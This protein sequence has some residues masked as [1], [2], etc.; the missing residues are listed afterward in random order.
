MLS[1]TDKN[2]SLTVALSYIGFL[3]AKEKQ[4]LEYKLISDNLD[5]PDKLELISKEYISF[6][7]MRN[8]GRSI[9]PID[10]L[11][12][13]TK[14]A[15]KIMEKYGIG[16]LRNDDNEFPQL[17]KEIH[18]MPYALYYRGN[19]GCLHKDCCAVV[20]TRRATTYGRKAAFVL[21]KEL[22]EN[23]ITVVSGLALG[24]DAMAHKGAVQEKKGATVAVLA[25]GLDNIYPR[26]N[27]QLA[28]K[29]IQNGGCL[30]SEYAPGEQPL[31]Y[32]FP[33][34]N[35]IIS[36]L[37]KATVVIEAPAKS[38]SLITADFAIEQ[39]RDLFFHEAALK[40]PDNKTDP[41]KWSARNYIEDGAPVVKDA[42][43][44]IEYISQGFNP[45]NVNRQL[46]LL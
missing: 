15:L 8:L 20:G 34:R 23:D 10:K 42:Q 9:W 27:V 30:L 6:A 1:I 18:D 37:S 38:G 28:A 44:V 12:I 7:V 5:T 21:A 13:K 14:R 45:C 29:I 46:E 11:A 17:L 40:Y 19:T 2:L 4:L 41:D 32:R 25:C 3:S 39:N 31:K 16:L 33:E 43:T 36:G 22:S 26:T 24:I 35:R